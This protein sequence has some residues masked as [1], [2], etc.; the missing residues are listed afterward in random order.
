MIV[1]LLWF[2]EWEASY[3]LGVFETE[4][5]AIRYRDYFIKFPVEEQYGPDFEHYSEKEDYEDRFVI[6]P[7]KI[8]ETTPKVDNL[9]FLEFIEGQKRAQ[10]TGRTES[11]QG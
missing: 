6:E 9:H 8:G 11:A 2:N 5:E 4:Q 10:E 7:R 1:F 3:C